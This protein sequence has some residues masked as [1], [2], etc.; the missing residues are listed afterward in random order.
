MG[1]GAFQAVDEMASIP[2]V[3][4]RPPR[5]RGR[6]LLGSLCLLAI[7]LGMT[8]AAVPWLFSTSA[9]RDGITAQIR[10]IT[11]LSTL[12]Q[13]KAVFV[14]LPQ[15]HISIDAIQFADPSGALRID[16][17]YLKGYLRVSALLRGQLE[18]ASVTLG[19]PQM[20]IDLAGR[21][22]RSDSAIGRAANAK[23]ATP[24]A[25]SADETRLG[26]LTLVNGRA[27]LTNSFG[28]SDAIVEAI[29]VTVDWRKLGASANINGTARFRDQGADISA[30]IE[31][32]A[33]LMRGGASGL[34]LKIDSP[35]L[36]LAAE[37]SLAS[38][39]Q[40]QFAGRVTASAPSLR[41]LVETGGYFIALPAPFENFAL[42]ADVNATAPSASFS[43]L[44]LQLD[45]NDYEGALAVLQGEGRPTLAGTLAANEL[46][47]RPFFANLSPIHGRDGQW[48]HDA[49]DL[50]E[51]NFADLDIRISAQ[52]LSL[53]GVDFRDAAFSV[54]K[55]DRR[56]DLALIRA[57]A[58]QGEVRGRASFIKAAGGLET[59][60]TAALAGVDAAAMWPGGVESIRITGT[61]NATANL[62]AAGL[63]MSE[64][65]RNLEGRA[66]IAMQNGEINGVNL[67]QALRSVDKRPLGLADDI[68]YG[69]TSFGSAGF[70]LQFAK[71]VATIEHG[72]MR[73]RAID[74]N[75]NGAIDFGDRTVDV[76]ATVMSAAPDPN[77]KSERPQFA[78]DVA[79]SWDELAL[80]PD[81]RSLIRQSGAAAPLFST[82]AKVAPAP[83]QH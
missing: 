30:A 63:N 32:P 39:P 65:M 44:R 74:L 23:S 17:A 70:G 20:V 61:V 73:S 50:D 16:A 8:A 49:F 25:S 26:V 83:P 35:A 45:G 53:P 18:I 62:Q 42:E 76:H 27:R 57:K 75:F 40:A 67:G 41:R 34:L 1:A 38:G 80:V 68:R 64:M 59:H 37:G 36:S 58:A 69:A 12:S 14:V 19:E 78:F 66:Q 33:D 46:S 71:G 56:V 81:A 10:Q 7:L 60:V 22:M 47:L 55:R 54:M 48:S 31:H 72:E 51:D 9:L 24:Q 28:D 82:G 11:G 29:N 2:T 6:I 13:G 79:G 21:P 3:S 77:S 4:S 5:K 43:N 52:R 15:P